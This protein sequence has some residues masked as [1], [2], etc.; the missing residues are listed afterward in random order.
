M[1]RRRRGL[2]RGLVCSCHVLSEFPVRTKQKGLSLFSC[3]PSA[4]FANGIIY[5]HNGMRPVLPRDTFSEPC[6]EMTN[7]HFGRTPGEKL[8]LRENWKARMRLRRLGRE[9]VPIVKVDSW[10]ARRA[11]ALRGVPGNSSH[12]NREAGESRSIYC[13]VLARSDR[14]RARI[15]RKAIPVGY[16]SFIGWENIVASPPLSKGSRLVLFP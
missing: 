16:I 3:L 7:T 5:I 11:V 1:P 13:V 6:S 9:R 2:T 12:P 4:K 8:C 14:D 15:C 10:L